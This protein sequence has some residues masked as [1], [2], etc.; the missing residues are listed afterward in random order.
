MVW[1]ISVGWTALVWRCLQ[2][3]FRHRKKT[4]NPFRKSEGKKSLGP[5][6]ER[7][8]DNVNLENTTKMVLYA[9]RFVN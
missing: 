5:G 3:T 4:K 2:I 8:T 9:V 7:P 1:F 6:V